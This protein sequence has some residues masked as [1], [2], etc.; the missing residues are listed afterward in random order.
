MLGI[1]GKSKKSSWQYDI[2]GMKS[3]RSGLEDKIEEFS[4]KDE[5]KYE[6]IGQRN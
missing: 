1:V 6:K 3:S 5:Q 4:E 2:A